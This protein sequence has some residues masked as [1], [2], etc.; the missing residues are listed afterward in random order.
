[1]RFSALRSLT[2]S[3]LVGLTTA[4]LGAGAIVAP[5]DA[6][7]TAAG[8]MRV[9]TYNIRA[10][11]SQASFQAAITAAKPLADVIGL[12]EIGQ[13]DKHRFL[14][15]D[16]D[17]GYYRPPALQ[18]NPVIWRR[19]LFDFVDAR[20]VK[21][22]EERDLGSEYP[23]VHRASYATVVRLRARST[24]QQVAFVN[25]H[26][27]HGSVKMGLPIPGK[28]RS[29]AYITEQIDGTTALLQDERG[30]YGNAAVYVLGDLNVSYKPDERVQHP[31]L[32]FRR[33]G[34]IGLTSMWKSSPYLSRSYGT[35]GTALL[36]QVWS[37]RPASSTTIVTAIKQSDHYPAVA[38]YDPP[39]AP[40]GYV[41]PRGT[42]GFADTVVTSPEG[43]RDGKAPYL[44]VGLTGDL[45]YGYARVELDRQASTAVEGKDFTFDPS[46]WQ[47]E[48]DGVRRIALRVLNDDV[49]EPDEKVVLRLVGP[50][51][52]SLLPKQTITATIEANRN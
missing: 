37:D 7:T 35:R 22:A 5:A 6:A 31:S 33:F 20:G 46:G 28:P 41:A 27:L 2:A 21:I 13:T 8:P 23:G 18:Q 40:A 15:K 4:T 51:N 12:Q 29:F 16:A 42:A 48:S 49:T 30:S 52:S 47:D 43:W 45:R 25:V 38:T 9:M 14:L 17:W 11:V 44:N 26:L 39:P 19:D 24:G 1:M 10:G 3:L 34:G 36:D 50:V 32:P